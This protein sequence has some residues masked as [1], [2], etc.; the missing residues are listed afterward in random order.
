MKK[1][2]LFIAIF[3]F[4]LVITCAL[5]AQSM[6]S[7]T[8]TTTDTNATPT[9]NDTQPDSSTTNTAASNQDAVS[10]S[11][12]VLTAGWQKMRKSWS[13]VNN[14]LTIDFAAKTISFSYARYGRINLT[15]NEVTVDTRTGVPRF[16]L[17]VSSRLGRF[18]LTVL[19][20]TSNKIYVG[21]DYMRGIRIWGTYTRKSG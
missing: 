15:I 4:S 9:T 21:H 18:K 5:A 14:T 11:G 7:D 10:T 17:Q 8:D 6:D 1:S 16:T 19:A 13:L 2:M 12:T 20:L 3:G